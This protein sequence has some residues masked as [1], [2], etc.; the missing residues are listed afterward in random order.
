MLF[1][2]EDLK[3][4]EQH[5]IMIMSEIIRP[6]IYMIEQESYFID[7]ITSF[8]DKLTEFQQKIL[9]VE[10][11]DPNTIRNSVSTEI[12][13]YKSSIYQYRLTI[14]NI[15]KLINR[16]N[17]IRKDLITA[18][19]NMSSDKS[20]LTESLSRQLNSY[21][22]DIELLHY[23]VDQCSV[24]LDQHKSFVQ[25]MSETTDQFIDK[26]LFWDPSLIF[27]NIPLF[28]DLVSFLGIREQKIMKRV[29]LKK[30]S[31]A[32]NKK[33]DLFEKIGNWV[34]QRSKMVSDFYDTRSSKLSGR[35]VSELEKYV[36]DSLKDLRQTQDFFLLLRKKFY[37]IYH[38]DDYRTLRSI[39][40]YMKSIG[41]IEKL[42]NDSSKIIKLLNEIRSIFEYLSNVVNLMDAMYILAQ[43][44]EQVLTSI[45]SFNNDV[46]LYLQ[47]ILQGA[48]L[49]LYNYPQLLK[50]QCNS[51][52]DLLA[53][54]HVVKRLNEFICAI[55][56]KDEARVS[57][58]NLLE[59]N[60][61][62]DIGLELID[63]DE[64]LE[65][66]ELIHSVA[67]EL[68]LVLEDSRL[69]PLMSDLNKLCVTLLDIRQDINDM[70]I[71]IKEKEAL[72]KEKLSELKEYQCVI[73]RL[74]LIC[75]ANSILVFLRKL[76]SI[77]ES[78]INVSRTM[79]TNNLFMVIMQ[80][81]ILY[82]GS[83]Q[84]ISRIASQLEE[85]ISQFVT[86]ECM[87]RL[88]FLLRVCMLISK[89]DYSIALNFT[90]K[91]IYNKVLN[92]ISDRLE[93]KLL[94]NDTYLQE[95]GVSDIQCE[96][97]NKLSELRSMLI[98]YGIKE[99][100][101]EL[102]IGNTPRLVKNLG[103]ALT[104]V[105]HILNLPSYYEDL[106]MCMEKMLCDQHNLSIAQF[107]LEC[108][109]Q[110]ITN[111]HQEIIANLSKIT[112]RIC[113]IPQVN[114]LVVQPELLCASLK[115]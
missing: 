67:G 9:F 27:E 57:F 53:N 83:D 16:Q 33:K 96:V 112:S 44:S 38:Y 62:L 109:K 19:H 75:V 79:T 65:I 73:H 48:L 17:S 86:S 103:I 77:P 7:A 84:Y 71:D 20:D 101:P 93:N 82:S 45:E 49:T 105:E 41:R 4:A 6:V 51:G 80:L 55:S 1:T 18:M 37:V 106:C 95:H 61:L 92:E 2:E 115:V 114:Q 29:F 10:R 97:R 36:T 89:R 74:Q 40:D 23:L 91:E 11:V 50:K 70:D 64:L 12:F 88:K 13:A 72:L 99:L 42:Q 113:E 59:S 15:K 102:F 98:Q 63:P 100:Q 108:A 60:E 21:N 111:P 87:V 107:E 56:K 3:K 5:R 78:D 81:M 46:V 22:K 28:N 35:D 8:F 43:S 32:V 66:V 25:Y 14:N 34:S 52:S 104:K 69:Q 30:I 26:P 31:E 24:I 90:K 85:E 110:G 39:L 54:S 47:T 94:E 68:P 58:S 76:P